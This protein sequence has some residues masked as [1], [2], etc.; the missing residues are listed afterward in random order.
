[1]K[2]VYLLAPE[3]KSPVDG[4]LLAEGEAHFTYPCY[5]TIDMGKEVTI[6]QGDPAIPLLSRQEIT[7][8]ASWYLPSI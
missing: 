8:R 1:M 2:R 6:P 5:D 7:E 3:A 4:T